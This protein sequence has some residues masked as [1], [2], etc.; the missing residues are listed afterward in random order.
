MTEDGGAQSAELRRCMA[1]AGLE[2]YADAVIPI[3]SS[4]QGLPHRELGQR[5]KTCGVSVLGHRHMLISLLSSPPASSPTEASVGLTV[6]EDAH[7]RAVLLPSHHDNGDDGALLSLPLPPHIKAMVA[8]CER[9]AGTVALPFYPKEDPRTQTPTVDHSTAGG[10]RERLRLADGYPGLWRITDGGGTPIY[11]C[12]SFLSDAECDDLVRLAD[13]L[14]LRSRTDGGESRT[15]TSRSCFLRWSSHPCPSLAR[16]MAA[17][18]GKPISH[19]ESPQ[20]CRYDEGQFY[21]MHFD[22]RDER[23]DFLGGVRTAT[24]GAG[25]RVCTCLIYLNDVA[26][27]GCTRFNRIGLELRPRK[28][29]A[30][31]FFPSFVDGGSDRQTLHEACPAIDRKYVCQ[32]WVRQRELPAEDR[33]LPAMGHRLLEALYAP[34][35]GPGPAEGGST[36]V[37]PTT[38]PG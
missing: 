30:A 16:K 17:L 1:D 36:W 27:G 14:L 32:L 18:T 38:E 5:L 28:G 35:A 31:I 26:R 12:D 7:R 23:A 21:G 20:V 3:A 15:R 6:D 29:T 8:P 24:H 34:R 33:D 25:Q 4:L 13:P 9:F 10:S 22:A 19:M 2:R 11:L 37:G